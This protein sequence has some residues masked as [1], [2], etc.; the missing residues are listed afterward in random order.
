MPNGD[1][2]QYN[3]EQPIEAEALEAL[4]IR[5]KEH[6]ELLELR[7]QADL[8]P[9]ARAELLER[10]SDIYKTTA[11]TLGLDFNQ[12]SDGILETNKAKNLR[13]GDTLVEKIRQAR[14]RQLLSAV[15]QRLLLPKPAPTDPSF[16]WAQT[17]PRLAPMQTSEFRDDGLH[18][19]GGP[20]VAGH[21]DEMHTSFGAIAMFGLAPERLPSSPSGRWLSS[22]MVELFG[23]VVAFAPDWDLLQGDGISSCDL[24]LR[25]TLYQFKPSPTGPLPVT[26]AESVSSNTFH[27]YLRNTGFSRNGQLPGFQLMPAVSVHNAQLVTTETLWV[28][29]EVRFDIYLNSAG[30]LLWCDPEVLLRLFQWPLVPMS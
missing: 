16:W 19:H 23:G 11:E 15:D 14:E 24:V 12:W 6:A 26:V 9:E 29:L 2:V 22:P 5:Y 8:P 13:V 21:N 30:A 10:R 4:E 18:F 25:Q 28:D 7:E 27:L 17:R 1:S 20:K 3:E